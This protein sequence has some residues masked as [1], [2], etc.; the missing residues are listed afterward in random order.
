MISWR[1]RDGTIIV[2][3]GE[4]LRSLRESNGLSQRA[5]AAR[6]G[7]TGAAVSSWETELCIPSL[8]QI[9]RITTVFGEALS[10]SGAIVVTHD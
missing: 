10:A 3:D 9:A 5:L 1:R 4:R 8:P 2:L 6:L 7:C